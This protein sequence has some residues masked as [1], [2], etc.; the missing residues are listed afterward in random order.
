MAKTEKM[1]PENQKRKYRTRPSIII[2]PQRCT[3]LHFK[4]KGC[5]EEKLRE[6]N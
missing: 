2:T 4:V 5:E 6:T 3:T 1:S